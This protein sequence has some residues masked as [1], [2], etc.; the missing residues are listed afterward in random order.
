MIKLAGLAT[1]KELPHRSRASKR[2][3]KNSALL[4]FEQHRRRRIMLK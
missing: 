4:M 1:S 3:N 2:T